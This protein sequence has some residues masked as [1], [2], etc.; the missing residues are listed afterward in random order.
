MES[1]KASEDGESFK[2]QKKK[3]DK[4]TK[5][6]HTKFLSELISDNSNDPTSLFKLIDSILSKSKENILPDYE[7]ENGSAEDLRNIS[8]KR[9][10]LFTKN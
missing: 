6:A 5:E 10:L 7:S 4:L 3:Y 1:F 2:A 9:F 8:W